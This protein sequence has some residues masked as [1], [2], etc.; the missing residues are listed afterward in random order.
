LVERKKDFLRGAQGT[1]KLSTFYNA[2]TQIT[3]F[4]GP[5]KIVAFTGGYISE[6]VIIS[7]VNLHAT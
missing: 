3:N 5:W 7:G 6:N 1:S 2:R 4:V